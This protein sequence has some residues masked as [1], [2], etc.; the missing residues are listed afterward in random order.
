MSTFIRRVATTDLQ[1][2]YIT[3]L[4]KSKGLK[5]IFSKI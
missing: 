2:Y 5:K 4:T 3:H 1:L